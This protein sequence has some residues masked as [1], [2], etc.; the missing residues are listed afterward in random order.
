MSVNAKSPMHS[1]APTGRIAGKDQFEPKLG[2][3]KGI[4]R[5][6]IV[7]S[8]FPP[9]YSLKV[10]AIWDF[11]SLIVQFPREKVG[12]RPSKDTGES[13][14]LAGFG[15]KSAPFSD[16]KWRVSFRRGKFLAVLGYRP[17]L[18]TLGALRDW[19][20]PRKSWRKADLSIL[21]RS[22]ECASMNA[23]CSLRVFWYLWCVYEKRRRW[24]GS[25]SWIF[26]AGHSPSPPGGRRPPIFLP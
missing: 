10:C 26:G 1:L 5:W 12:F 9:P 14:P 18:G 21:I 3:L 8:R 20:I 4:R 2:L 25:E 17:I 15:R 16:R 11:S 19:R 22:A 23:A 6:R 13:S 7:R 24:M